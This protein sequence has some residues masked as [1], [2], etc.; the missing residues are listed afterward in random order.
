MFL[1]FIVCVCVFVYEVFLLAYVNWVFWSEKAFNG[2]FEVHEL[3]KERNISLK[4][5]MPYSNQTFH[6]SGG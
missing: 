5:E 3:Q 6:C 1:F 2:L 4:K